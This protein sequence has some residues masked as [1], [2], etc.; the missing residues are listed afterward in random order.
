MPDQHIT[1]AIVAWLCVLA[2]ALAYLLDRR[3][4]DA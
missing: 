2:Y 1:V 3:R 4:D